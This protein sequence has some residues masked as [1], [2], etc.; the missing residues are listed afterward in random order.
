[1]KILIISF[2]YPPAIYG[3]L[4]RHV[5]E[6]S[7]SLV[8]KGHEV[9]V[10]AGSREDE[11]VELKGVEVYFVGTGPTDPINQ[12]LLN[13]H[14]SANV[15]TKVY[16]ILNKIG[17]VDI[18]HVHD[19]WG[20]YAGY[21]LKQVYHVPMIVTFHITQ[22]GKS[23]SELTDE[24]FF[25]TTVENW[26]LRQADAVIC[27][28]KFIKKEINQFFNFNKEINVIP[29]GVRADF[30][31]P[32]KINNNT[33]PTILFAGRL[34]VEKGIFVLL[35]SIQ[36]VI[37]KYPNI[38][39]HIC[40]DGYLK[41]ELDEFIIKHGLESYICFKG[42]LN[43]KEMLAEYQKADIAIFPSLYE[44]FGLVVL[45]AMACGLPIIVTNTGGMSE[46]VNHRTNGLKVTPGKSLPI[47]KKIEFLLENKFEAKKMGERAREHVI[48]R[49]CWATV[50][51]KTENV[52]KQLIQEG[53]L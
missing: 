19:I 30:F 3:G 12:V 22:K 37:K 11:Y 33:Y 44:P 51:E 39:L 41:D 18:V 20:A 49:Y 9:I 7:Q 8:K 36:M 47:A 4:G 24:D 1:M 28:S 50:V 25:L 31:Q 26:L 52:Y 35:N 21:I 5:E 14:Y 46:I 27:C 32:T 42:F 29:N 53:G 2:E 16:E 10:I 23:L 34:V 43:K 38:K 45:E 17:N 13:I 40:G 6:L 48:K 15:V